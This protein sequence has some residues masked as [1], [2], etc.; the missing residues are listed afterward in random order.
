MG[1]LLWASL[2]LLFC[3]FRV[4]SKERESAK[5]DAASRLMRQSIHEQSTGN[6]RLSRRETIVQRQEAQ[7][8]RRAQYG[9]SRKVASQAL[10]Y[11]IY[12]SHSKS[13]S[14]Y[15]L[16]EKNSGGSLLHKRNPSNETY[17][18]DPAMLE[19]PLMISKHSFIPK[20]YLVRMQSTA[21]RQ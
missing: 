20:K 2:V 11:V 1:V 7:S 6:R 9:R 10:V 15:M 14:A 18:T 16:V 21:A 17:Y 8:C 3:C 19:D 13:N 5:F 4:Y 12:D